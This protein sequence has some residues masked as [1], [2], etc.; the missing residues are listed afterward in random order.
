[1][2]ITKNVTQKQV[3]SLKIAIPKIY[4]SNNPGDYGKMVIEYTDESGNPSSKT[5]FIE[6]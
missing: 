2:T 5:A 6:Q 4:A 3:D 1:M